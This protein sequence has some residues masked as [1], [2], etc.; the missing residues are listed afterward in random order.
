MSISLAD[1]QVCCEFFKSSE[2]SNIVSEFS[3]IVGAYFLGPRTGLRHQHERIVMG[4]AKNSIMGLFMM[5]WAALA[6]NSGRY[7]IFLSLNEMSNVS[8]MNLSFS[9]FGVSEKK[10]MFAARA[11]VTT[12]I[13]SW[14]GGLMGLISCYVLFGGK[15]NVSYVCSC[16]FGSL[17]LFLPGCFIQHQLILVDFFSFRLQ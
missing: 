7:S 2:R 5:W 17:V 11:T 1:F 6:F 16:V 12:M 13:S 4:N 3:G 10:W 9:T 14:G 8:L 15:I